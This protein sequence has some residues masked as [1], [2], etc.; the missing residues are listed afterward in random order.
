MHHYLKEKAF[1][2]KY[3]SMLQYLNSTS[4]MVEDRMYKEGL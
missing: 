3:L 2:V 1:A 4:E